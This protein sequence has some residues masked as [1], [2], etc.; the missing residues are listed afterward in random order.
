MNTEES[1]LLQI[2]VDTQPD[3]Y[4]VEKVLRHL[5]ILANKFERSKGAQN[6]KKVHIIT[7][8]DTKRETE[9]AKVYNVITVNVMDTLEPNVER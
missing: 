8:T 2:A 5:H 3:F 4:S 6:K 9:K 1:R 7:K